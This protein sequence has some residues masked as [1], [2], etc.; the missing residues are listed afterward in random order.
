MTNIFKGTQGSWIWLVVRLYVGYQ[1]LTAGWGKATGAKAFDATGFLKGAIAKSVPAAPGGKP[2]V[3]A[4]WGSFLEGFALPNVKLFNFMI[5]YGEIL[6]GLALIL[7]FATI[8]AAVMGMVMNFAFLLSGTTSSNPNLLALQFI[9]VTLGGAYAGYLGADYYFRPL[10]RSYL[11]R[12]LGTDG[13]TAKS[14]A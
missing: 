5:V 11:G 13:A 12:L 2:V 4:W 10:Y 8:F 3:Q 14:A 7:G 9:L 1:W 6:V